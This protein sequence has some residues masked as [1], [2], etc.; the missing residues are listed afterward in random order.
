MKKKR[1]KKKKSKKEK[2]KCDLHLSEWPSLKCLQRTNGQEG[3]EKTEAAYTVDG[4][5]NW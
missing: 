3:V 4:H 1:K 5:V 2:E